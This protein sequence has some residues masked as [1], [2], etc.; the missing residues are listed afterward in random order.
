MVLHIFQAEPDKGEEERSAVEIR[1]AEKASVE[2]LL[3]WIAQ[4]SL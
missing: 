2:F 3:I 4:A 1:F